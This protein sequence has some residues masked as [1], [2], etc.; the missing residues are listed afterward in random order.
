MTRVTSHSSS[1]HL[2]GGGL[3]GTLAKVEMMWVAQWYPER[4]AAALCLVTGYIH[5]LVSAAV[6]ADGV[7][8]SRAI[9][10]VIAPPDGLS[11]LLPTPNTAIAATKYKVEVRAAHVKG[12]TDGLCNSVI[13]QAKLYRGSEKPYK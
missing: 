12:E 13:T 2:I 1:G 11:C 5:Q 8:M 4:G 7:I 6:F 9:L 10:S 3:G